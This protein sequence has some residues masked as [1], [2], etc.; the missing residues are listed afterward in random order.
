MICPSTIFWRWEFFICGVLTLW[1]HSTIKWKPLDTCG[2][3]YVRK[4]VEAVTLPSNESRVVIKFIKKC[5]FTCFGTPRAIISYGGKHFINNLFKNL[6]AKYYIR[7]KV[8]TTYHP[9]TSVQVELLNREV[10][11]I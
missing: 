6:L 10:K 11:Q 1:V 2:G 8:A 4:W 5:I 7:H 3:G 9:Q